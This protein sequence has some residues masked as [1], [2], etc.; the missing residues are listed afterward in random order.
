[1]LKTLDQG[2]FAGKRVLCRIDADVP[3]THAGT[4][5]D[6]H[7]LDV[8][9][10]TIRAI[11]AKVPQSLILLA[12]RGQPKI[13]PD[14]SL[15]LEPA[16]NY[17]KQQLLGDATAI[18]ERRKAVFLEGLDIF[19][20][21]DSVQLVE[22]IRHTPKDEA[23]DVTF[24]Q[25]LAKQ[26]DLF[27]F[28]AFATA[29]RAHASTA[30]V[31]YYLPHYA[32]LSVQEE[33]SALDSLKLNAARPSIFIIGGAKIEDKL[34]VIEQLAEQSDTFLVGGAVANTFLKSTDVDVKQ[35]LVQDEFVEKARSLLS[36]FEDKIQLPTDFEWKDDKIVDIGPKT[37]MHFEDILTDAKTVFWNGNLGKTEEREGVKGSLMIADLLA[38]SPQINRIVAG[39]DTVGFLHE[40]HL[41]EQMNFVSTGGGATLEY[42]AGKELPAITALSA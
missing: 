42:L 26:A 13:Y 41:A 23:N 34:P 38:K 36:Q 35:S 20:L 39:G 19:T 29:H 16:A 28:N 22:N 31:S 40:H 2:D 15:T 18:A 14:M 8:S 27:V 12:H 32:G 37:I 6:T 1:M 17:L 9:L 5:E 24:A 10:E 33:V 7:R 21:T 25:D 11:L 3:F 4:I 30:G